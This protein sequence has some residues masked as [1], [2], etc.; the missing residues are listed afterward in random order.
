MTG[1]S[2]ATEEDPF[3]GT[4][5]WG[6]GAFNGNK[7]LK[8]IIQ[9]IAASKAKVKK[10]VYCSMKDEGFEKDALKIIEF[11]KN[12]HGKNL[13]VKHLYNA[14][15]MFCESKDENKFMGSSINCDLFLKMLNKQII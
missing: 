7:I 2:F 6:C 15:L 11:V 4:G 3:I 10:V 13:S 1:F 8:F 5:H 9:W 12:S 14:I